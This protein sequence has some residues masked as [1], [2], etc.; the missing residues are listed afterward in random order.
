MKNRPALFV[1]AAL[2]VTRIIA[3]AM[4]PLNETTEARY[5][6]MARKMLEG[7]AD[8]GVSAKLFDISSSDRTE[9][10]KEMLDAK[11]FLIGSSTHDNDMLPAM[12]GFLEFLKG[13]WHVK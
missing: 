12:A 9:I 11:G 13:Q 6:E 8:A 3:M 4:I 10:I 5:G 7:M 1:L 2:L